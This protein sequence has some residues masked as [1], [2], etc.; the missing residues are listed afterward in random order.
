MSGLKIQEGLVK[1]K[2]H[3]PIIFVTAH[4]DI[5]M[6]VSAMKAGA[7]DFLTKPFCNQ[8]LL[9]AV[10]TA[11]AYDVARREQEQSISTLREHFDS[12]SARERDVVARIVAGELNKQIAANLGL[13]E[14]TVKLHRAKAMHKMRAKSLAELVR[15]VDLLEIVET[16]SEAGF[17][18][19]SN[20]P[21]LRR[22][23]RGQGSR[24]A[25]VSS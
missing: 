24:V 23:W 5:Q 7:V 15:M 6:A 20:A 17:S 19:I 14:V 21:M 3:V 10:F 9:D 13:S 18:S 22:W 4:G 12:L 8:E 1:A 2:V 16:R 11:L 25:E